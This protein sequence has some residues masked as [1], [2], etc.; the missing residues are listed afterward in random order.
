MFRSAYSRLAEPDFKRIADE[1]HS[2]VAPEQVRASQQ[3]HLGEQQCGEL[4]RDGV[5]C[6]KHRHSKSPGWVFAAEVNP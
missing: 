1:T 3:W 4:D 5:T 6:L 2:F